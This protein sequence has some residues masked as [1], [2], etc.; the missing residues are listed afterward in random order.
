VTT[1]YVRATRQQLKS[2][3]RRLVSILSGG[4]P[5]EGGIAHGFAMRLAYALLSKVKLAY[6]VKARGGTDECGISWPP[7]TKRYLA[8]QRGPK[9]DRTA[10]G[11]SPGGKDGFMSPG[12]L[13][14][15]KR[16]Y[17]GAL[18]WMAADE[19][20][21]EET[22]RR[23]AAWAWSRAKARGVRTKL[24]VFGSRE[25]EILRDRDILLNS[26]SPGALTEAGAD[27]HYI[28]PDG[29]IVEH[30]PG[31][32]IVGSSVAYAGYHQHAKSEK[33]RRQI[34]PEP[35]QI[36]SSWWH[37]LASASTS[38]IEQAIRLLLGGRAR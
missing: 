8:Y 7:L 21:S 33:R 22:K 25:H 13:A 3:L 26:L 30:N 37:F 14:Q 12:E 6:I 36:P 10:G 34:V 2:E 31:E 5:D 20:L 32:V 1:I 15:W 9:S 19:G 16:D 17:A 38:G 11:L 23:A 24:D 35:S 27:A 18:T 28:G 4:Q 29:Q